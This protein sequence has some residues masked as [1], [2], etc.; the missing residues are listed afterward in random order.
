[1]EADAVIIVGQ[2][3]LAEVKHVPVRDGDDLSA[4]RVVGPYPRRGS[5]PLRCIPPY[6]GRH[7]ISLEQNDKNE[8]DDDCRDNEAS[9]NEHQIT[10]NT[11]RIRITSKITSNR[12]MMPPPR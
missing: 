5:V 4:S 10:P 12:P 3:G 7:Y 6:P 11:F 9:A 1:V 8:N 2:C